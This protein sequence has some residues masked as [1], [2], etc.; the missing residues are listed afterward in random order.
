[1]AGIKLKKNSNPAEQQQS[2]ISLMWWAIGLSRPYRK[3]VIIILIA[4]LMEAVMSV[5]TPWPLKIIIDDI[6]GHGS[7]PK[8]LHWAGFLFPS[9]NKVAMAALIA[10]GFVL[11]NV[12][13]SLSGYINSYYNEDVA[14]HVAN[15]L[16]RR[17]Y[18]HLQRL[19][20]LRKHHG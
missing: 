12:I 11:I 16:R 2:F 20:E 14:Q 9:G 6:V 13:G 18:H 8:W 4:M 3:W 5:A 7:L 10:F 15:D 19:D 17:I 1:M